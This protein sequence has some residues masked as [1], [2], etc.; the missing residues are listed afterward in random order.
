MLA[1][2]NLKSKW[3]ESTVA[4]HLKRLYE[5]GYW[6]DRYGHE[7]DFLAQQGESLLPIEVKFRQQMAKSD[8]KALEKLKAGLI[9]TRIQWDARETFLFI[10][11]ALYLLAFPNH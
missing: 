11:T 3:V 1:D 9:L 5:V 8:L 10:P 2:T 6:R 4:A 7:V